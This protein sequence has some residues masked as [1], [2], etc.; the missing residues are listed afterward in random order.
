MAPQPVAKPAPEPDPAPV[1]EP[2]PEPVVP[3]PALVTPVETPD[4]A[5]AAPKPRVRTASLDEKRAE[6]KKQA[7]AEKRRKAEEKKQAEAEKKK[8]DEKK[9]ADAKRVEQAKADEAAKVA[10]EVASIINNEDSRGATSGDGGEKTLGKQDGRSATLSQS[11]IDG[12]VSQIRG[13]LNVPAGAAESGLT[14]QLEFSIDGSGMVTQLPRVISSPANALEQALA[15]AA[16]RAVMRCGPYQVAG[17]EVR[18]TFDPR[19]F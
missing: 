4:P 3:E 13:C 5:E 16:Q 1:E 15:S 9:Q 17:Q 14:A 10:D 11:E 18:A 12:L 2:V 19:E 7:E 8:A 6:F